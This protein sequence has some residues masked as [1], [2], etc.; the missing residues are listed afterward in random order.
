MQK[1]IPLDAQ[2]HLDSLSSFSGQNRGPMNSQNIFLFSRAYG[3][4]NATQ[5]STYPSV[6]VCFIY[7]SYTH[8]ILTHTHSLTPSMGNKKISF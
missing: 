3:T 2:F 7:R 8:N 5:I 1:T 4:L 6:F